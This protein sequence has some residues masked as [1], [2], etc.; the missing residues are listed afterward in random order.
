MSSPDERL[1]IIN[2]QDEVVGT[3]TRAEV[4]A[5]KLMHRIV[6]VI[7]WNAA[8]ELLLQL[9]PHTVSLPNHWTTSVGGHVRAGESYI[10]AAK[11]EAQEEIGVVPTLEL[12]G[13]PWFKNTNGLHKR[14]TVFRAQHEGPFTTNPEEVAELA[15]FSQQKTTD[16]LASGALIHPE[17]LFLL[18]NG[19]IQWL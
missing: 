19:T 11:R 17:L 18:T 4:Y 3:A 9:R 5:Q 13:Q 14:L 6:H 8:G 16:L 1:D 12:M 10:D 15:F 2:E 7:V